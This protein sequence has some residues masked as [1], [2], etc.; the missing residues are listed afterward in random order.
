M[1]VLLRPVFSWSL[2]RGTFSRR[3]SAAPPPFKV[4]VVGAGPAGLYVGYRL[5][6]QYHLPLQVDIF[7][8]QA[9]PYGL[10]RFGVAPDHPEV[11]NCQDQFRTVLAN[12][13]TRF[14]GNV[15]VVGHL[16]DSSLLLLVPLAPDAVEL[17]ATA[18]VE[19]RQ[20]ISLAALRETYD[21]VVLSYGCQADK[22]FPDSTKDR[23]PAVIPARQFV[24]WYNNAPEF[25]LLNPPLHKVKEVVVVGNGN[26]ALDVARV[27]LAPTSHWQDTDMLP[28]AI[29]VLRNSTVERVRLVA[30]RGFYDSAFTNKE[31]RELLDLLNP[32]KTPGTTVHFEG[33]DEAAIAQM[34]AMVPHMGRVHK[35]RLDMYRKFQKD[36]AGANTTTTRTWSLDY[37]LSP[38]LF[39]AS[40]DDPQLLTATHFTKNRLEVDEALLADPAGPKTRAVS[41]RESQVLPLQ[42]VIT[43]I[44]YKGEPLPGMLQNGICFDEKHGV[45][46]SVDGRVR[47]PAGVTVPGVYAAGWIKNGPLGVIATTMMDAFAVA[48]TI[49][50]DRE[51]QEASRG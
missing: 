34:E 39:E 25:K 15:D 1:L 30:R 38:D 40:K 6:E 13:S 42:L 35:R 49:I 37:L 23:H 41:T 5:Y 47:S 28:E 32:K 11:K 4:A 22:H 24:G 9:V 2:P 3:L 21:A 26:V 8:K 43:S 14:F 7:E 36:V 46:L 10:S 20:Q 19:P 29:D 16:D 48:E 44:G 12:P 33:I 31:F 17:L 27:L 51:N 50:G 18:P 45:V